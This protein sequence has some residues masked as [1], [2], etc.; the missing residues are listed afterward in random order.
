MVRAEDFQSTHRS[1]VEAAEVLRRAAQVSDDTVTNLRERDPPE[2][3]KPSGLPT[4]SRAEFRDFIIA[5]RQRAEACG[6]L[7][8]TILLWIT[9]LC[10]TV[11]HGN[12]S[13]VYRIRRC[14]HKTIS[15]IRVAQ[16]LPDGSLGPAT[17]LAN[18][19]STEEVWAWLSQGLVPALGGSQR[20]PGYTC[21]FNRLV[22]RVMLRQSRRTVGACKVEGPLADYYRGECRSSSTSQGSFGRGV[23][24][25][26]TGAGVADP[27][28]VAGSGMSGI[29]EDNQ[30]RFF[31][32]L[33]TYRQQDA[34]DRARQL[35]AGSW[36]DDATSVLEVQAAFFNAEV[37]AFTLMSLT[38]TF[39]GG[40]LV[41]NKLELSPLSTRI[42]PTAWY[43]TVDIVWVL[44]I[45]VF[46]F[47]ALQDAFDSKGEG[48]TTRRCG[49]WWVVLDWLSIAVGLALVGFFV[50]FLQ[51][52]DELEKQVGILGGGLPPPTA[53]L[54]FRNASAS[55]LYDGSLTNVLE[56]IDDI[57]FYKMCQR[58]GMFWYCMLLLCR[59][60]RGFTGQPRIRVI[61]LTFEKASA[62]VTHF[63]ILLVAICENFALGG[64]VLFGPEL[65][66]WASVSSAHRSTLAVLCGQADFAA[67]YDV[68]PLRA[69]IW[70]VM[71]I[72][73][74]VFL[75]ANMVVAILVDY[76]HEA[77]V[78]SGLAATGIFDQAYI[79]LKTC[80]WKLGYHYRT[81][82]HFVYSRLSPSLRRFV[83]EPSDEPKRTQFIP[84]DELLDAVLEGTQEAVE[85]EMLTTDAVPID[86]AQ[87]FP[88]NPVTKELLVSCG[89]DPSTADHLLWKC[90]A[91]IGGRL[92]DAFPADKLFFEFQNAMHG[93]YEL[94]DA[95]G[96]ELH[97]WLADR[98]V[99]LGNIE[100]RQRKLED[101]SV[102]IQPMQVALEGVPEL[103]VLDGGGYGQ[104]LGEAELMQVGDRL[105]ELQGEG[106]PATDSSE[107][108][109]VVPYGQGNF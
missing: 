62:D 89:C 33:D 21:T 35:A 70:L 71:F 55:L 99:D 10:V 109:A 36:C 107:T 53:T 15:E 105:L 11:N 23:V 32:W 91:S 13:S 52:V 85:Q 39:E 41:R 19:T 68:A 14:L 77:K 42:Y 87:P 7:P 90:A 57:I 88:W 56:E 31:G 46:F 29:S 63:G 59:F 81:V 37:Q 80:D 96:E 22:G 60:F 38:F 64:C 73:S 51:G 76:Y 82:H 30:R 97:A 28:F 66:D 78:D 92:P 95:I 45:T 49:S 24:G 17:S 84:Y 94:L 3:V 86:P 74:V 103:P 72:V 20:R 27:A 58:L 106:G 108:G 25:A 104:A 102:T 75:V 40:G 67:M 65:S 61:G 8:L 9:F 54:M 79:F 93:S 5:E 16:P 100:P 6:T 48:G 98:V 44:L 2:P 4:V 47:M 50:V 34:Q 43:I 83:R 12:I 26:G 69:T 18:M 101:A 1:H